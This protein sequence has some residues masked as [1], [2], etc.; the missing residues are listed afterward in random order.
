M[1]ADTPVPSADQEQPAPPPESGESTLPAWDQADGVPEDA[2]LGDAV[3]AVVPMLVSVEDLG[4]LAELADLR[5][6][7]PGTAADQLLEPVRDLARIILSMGAAWQA[8]RDLSAEAA[9]SLQEPVE[10]TVHEDQGWD[11]ADLEQRVTDAVVERVLVKISVPE[12]VDVDVL[13]QEVANRLRAGIERSLRLAD[14]LRTVGSFKELQAA[15]A[16]VTQ[17]E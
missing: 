16:Q 12:K 8:V 13:A 15:A 17:Q 14:S 6:L 7:H 11:T 3:P 4:R 2:P 9:A 5:L 1:S 10:C